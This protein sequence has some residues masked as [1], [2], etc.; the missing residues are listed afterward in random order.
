MGEKIICPECGG[1][2]GEL[3][4]PT[5]TPCTCHKKAAEPQQTDYQQAATIATAAAAAEAESPKACRIC[6]KD[7]TN[8]KR[9]KD[10]LGYWC[11]A[12]HRAD[13]EKRTADMARCSN[14]SRM[15]PRHKLIESD[16]ERLCATCNRERLAQQQ[17]KLRKLA[18]GR[19]YKL[20]ERKQLLVLLGIFSILVLIIL[21]QKIG[22][23]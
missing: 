21:F 4:Q 6:G 3:T 11:E 8:A 10:S 16:T 13:A 7:V 15:F 5:D 1:V 22:L 20:H 23:L 9:Y 12:C 19:S 18:V 17:K 2:I 14:C